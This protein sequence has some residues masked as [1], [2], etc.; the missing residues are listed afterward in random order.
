MRRNGGITYGIAVGCLMAGIKI[1]MD[2]G[3]PCFKLGEMSA[4]GRYLDLY[5]I[6]TC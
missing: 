6:A 5:I 2:C 3:S 4:R 1:K